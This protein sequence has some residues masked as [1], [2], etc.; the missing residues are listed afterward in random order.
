MRMESDEAWCEW[1]ERK[2]AEGL[3]VPCLTGVD[4]TGP[5]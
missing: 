4:A 5:S 3:N 2:L 1:E